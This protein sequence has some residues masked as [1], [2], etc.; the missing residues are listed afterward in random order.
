MNPCYA[1]TSATRS[2]E[3]GIH[4][5]A[6]D[7]AQQANRTLLT[8]RRIAIVGGCGRVGLPLGIAFAMRGRD[9]TLL[10]TRWDAV[11]Q[12]NAGHLP[13]VEPDTF[14]VTEATGTLT[15]TTDPA[16]LAGV[17]VVIVVVGTPIDEHHNPDPVAVPNLIRD[18]KKH[19]V[20]GQLVILR[21]TLYPGTT[22][23]VEGVLA[24]RAID[25]A[26][27]PERIAEGRAMSELFELPQIVGARTARV[28]G[29]AAA[30]FTSL[31]P[32]TVDVTPE[33]AE[34][35]KLFTNAYRYVK[36][37][38]ANQLFMLAT[39]AGLDYDIIR[40]AITW[41]YPRAA[42]LPAAGFVAGPC[43]LKDTLQLAAFADNQFGL[44]HAATLINEGLPLYVASRID[45]RYGLAAKSIGILGM[46]FKGNS[47]DTRDSLAWKLRKILRGRALDVLCTDPHVV[48]DRLDS[49]DDVLR[50]A[51][52]LVIAADHDEYRDLKTDLPVVDIWGYTQRGIRL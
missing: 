44:G 47:D 27:C 49:L 41:G 26:A 24:D 4:G 5:Q 46:A 35:A 11:D 38:I 23:A 45:E 7:F 15:A 37:A 25:V 3:C 39:N 1:L 34:L 9:V 33:E 29:R 12:V 16:A 50:H 28:T 6:C 40:E 51:D 21:S 43:L 20:D 13:Y 32:N 22:A 8:D 14:D 31:T 18:L 52:V 36:F 42:D 10:D 17:G 30:V 48:D 2:V 19:L